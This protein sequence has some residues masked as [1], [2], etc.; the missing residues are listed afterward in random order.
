MNALQPLR[1]I[2][3]PVRAPRSRSRT[4]PRPHRHSHRTVAFEM[5]AKLAVNL[6]FSAVAVITL[7]KIMPYQ[8]SQQ[9]KLQEIRAEV[10]LAGGRVDRLNANFSRYFD[11][12][13]TRSAMQEQRLWVD[14][15]QKPVVWVD[16]S[17]NA[18]NL[19]P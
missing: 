5:V 12:K 9:E 16:K 3:Q 4:A 15:Q 19:E 2:L 14:S 18:A 1:P 13:Q 17:K 6:A 10:S 11:T 7:V 8:L